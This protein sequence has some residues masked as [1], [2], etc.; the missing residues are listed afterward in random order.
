MIVILYL[1]FHIHPL[2]HNANKD[3][4]DDIVES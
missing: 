3:E 1:T 2:E 4:G